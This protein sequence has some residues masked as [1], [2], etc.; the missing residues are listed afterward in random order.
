MS[1]SSSPRPQLQ[2]AEDSSSFLDRPRVWWASLLL[3]LA[4]LTV[5]ILAVEVPPLTDYPNHLARCYILA[6]GKSDPIL[7]RMFSAHWQIIP[8]IGADLILPALMHIV[9]PLVAGRITLALCLLLPT[10]GAIAL[11]YAYF[12]QRSF[13]QI[14]A[15]F[16]AY[17]ALFFLGFMNFELAIGIAL[18]G[19]AGW[20]CYREERPSAT[21]AFGAAIATTA[22]F[23]HLVGFC[24]FALLVGTYELEAICRAG[25]RTRVAVQ[26]AAKRVLLLVATLAVP[27]ILYVLSPFG[28][29]GG[30]IEW[31]R[32]KDKIF[33]LLVP[34]QDY[35]FS[36]DILLIAPVVAFL[37]LCLLTRRARIS[38]A[39]L[40]SSL[41]LLLGYA[42]MPRGMKGGYFADLRMPIMLGFLLFAAFIPAKLTSRQKS[43]AAFLF[44]ALFLARIAFI[45]TTW[46][47]AQHDV[48][49]VRQVIATVPPGSTVLAVDVTWHDNPDWF[50]SMP[51]SRW[52]P[53][54]TVTYTHLAAFALLDRHAFWSNIFAAQA[55]QP[56]QLLP[57]YRDLRVVESPPPGYH[58]LSAKDFSPIELK[59]FPFLP[60]WSDKF[61]YVLVLNAEGAPDLEHFLP[62]RLHFVERRGIAAL[63]KV[64]HKP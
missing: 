24:F 15:G 61:D 9:P 35:S 59:R 13:W 48:S 26:N 19:A 14:A 2:M 51:R 10:T 55:Q 18:W 41:I 30:T 60:D 44:A 47:Q 28:K 54:L 57:P 64:T 16:A 34:F 52:L 46:I 32:S 25:L 21:V 5:P 8:N 49:D 36:L 23:F 40:I 43:A 58:L 11:S 33:N 53:H 31:A 56:L 20:V 39:G 37:A 63:L 50:S 29:V 6:F 22:F 17:N 27:L 1:N 7:S 3:M 42:I 4:A 12:R 62:D 38:P 45:T